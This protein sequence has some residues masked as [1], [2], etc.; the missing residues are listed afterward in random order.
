MFYDILT[1]VFFG[2]EKK[3]TR[4]NTRFKAFREEEK[5]LV[6]QTHGYTDNFVREAI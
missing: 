5:F 3:G 6:I 2:E 4:G 1:N